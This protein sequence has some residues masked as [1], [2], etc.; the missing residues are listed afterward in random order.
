ME[1]RAE[2]DRV[3]VL[4]V[5]PG[6][7]T[8]LAVVLFEMGRSAP[9][10]FWQH[11]L[12][13]YEAAFEVRKWTR[14]LGQLRKRP[15]CDALAVGE[16][17]VINARTYQRGQDYVRDA[18]G[19]LGVLRDA[20]CMAKVPLEQGQQASDVKKLANDDLLRSLGLYTPGS[21]HAN[22][23]HRHVVAL[24]VKRNLIDRRTLLP[25]VDGPE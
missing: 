25:T 14:E 24:A 12:P 18:T 6:T 2:L 22:D 5:D 19:M 3:Y 10:K 23:A 16:K 20:A 21:K 9:H 15:G 13:W 7:T 11:E 17:F 8:G 1:T 4:G